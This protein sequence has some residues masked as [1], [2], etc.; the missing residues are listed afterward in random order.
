MHVNHLLADEIYAKIKT[1]S[2]TGYISMGVYLHIPNDLMLNI[3]LNMKN[4]CS[5]KKIK[6]CF[7][8]LI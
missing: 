6:N 2:P 8:C 3:G 4:N 5:M 7:F 1:S